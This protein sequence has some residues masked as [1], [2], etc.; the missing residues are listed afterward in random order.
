MKVFLPATA[1][2]FFI[3]RI[4][5]GPGG[6]TERDGERGREKEGERK[7]SLVESVRSRPWNFRN[8]GEG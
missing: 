8:K 7:R 3:G 2:M 5:G 6:Q 4:L 1:V